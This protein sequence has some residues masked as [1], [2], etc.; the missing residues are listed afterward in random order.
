MALS[1]R[2]PVP[3]GTRTVLATPAWLVWMAAVVVLGVGA[4]GVARD[5]MT[6][7]FAAYYTAA[8]LLADGRLAPWVY[9]EARFAYAVRETTGSRV[10]DVFGPNPPSMALLLGPLGMPAPGVARAIWL[11]VS[12]A[13][14]A[15]AVA[16]LIARGRASDGLPPSVLVAVAM[17][18]PPVWANLR[19]AQAYLVVGAMLT[20]SAL[21][22]VDRRDARAGAGLGLALLTKTAGLPLLVA[23]IAAGRRVTALAAAAVGAV[24]VLAVAVAAGPDLWA[25][26][27]AAVGAFV[28]DGR[29]AVPAYQT[30]FG[31]ARR[32]C[33]ADPRWNPAP[34]ADCAALAWGL[35]PLAVAAALA[36][37]AWAA[38]TARPDAW[39]AAGLSL[40]V[41]A[42]PVAEDHQFAL[43]GPALILL[44]QSREATGAH[45]GRAARWWFLVPAALLVV[46]LPVAV[47]PEAAGWSAPLAYPR[48][49][50][51]AWVWGLAW[52]A[53]RASSID[54][55]RA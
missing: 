24:G 43:L 26:Y 47:G 31:L 51:A 21:A 13:L 12:V 15:W 33:V 30:V 38:R 28:G 3:R 29:I 17:L 34:A 42:L 27:P 11:A 22:L 52:R 10:L 23:A 8:R 46:P 55:G 19:T 16:A 44:H 4:V 35:P 25:R 2:R 48:L 39:T 9:D 20:L 53:M 1:E 49:Y 6:H 40:S 37:T 45:R 36:A 50:A 41:L 7:G 5:R 32:L 18:G 54:A 14:W